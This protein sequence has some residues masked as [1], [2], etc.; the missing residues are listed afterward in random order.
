[1]FVVLLLQL[2]NFADFCVP[3][4]QVH[5]VVVTLVKEDDALVAAP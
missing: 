3:S 5:S 1:M 4:D 2:Q